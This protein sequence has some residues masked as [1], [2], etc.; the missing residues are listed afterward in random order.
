MKP[1]EYPILISLPIALA[2]YVL[3]RNWGWWSEA[4]SDNVEFWFQVV[5]FPIAGAFFC[6]LLCILM[7]GVSS[8][9]DSTV[10]SHAAQFWS[11]NWTGK[12]VSMRSSDGVEGSISGGFFMIQGR[13]GSEIVYTYYTLNEDGSFQPGKWNADQDTSIYEED[14]KDGSVVQYVEKFA[15]SKLNWISTPDVRLRMEFHIPKGSLQQNFT[16]K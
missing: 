5:V 8:L 3:Y 6:F 9:I 11:Q 4:G 12:M 10:A 1:I 14:R 7:L 16:I 15:N 2:F 13:I